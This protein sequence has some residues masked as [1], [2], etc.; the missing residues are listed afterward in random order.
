M[1]NAASVIT[2][3]GEKCPYSLKVKLQN[4]QN[5][6]EVG[7]GFPIDGNGSHATVESLGVGFGNN[8]AAPGSPGM[9]MGDQ[10]LKQFCAHALT[11]VVGVN[12]QMFEFAA[13]GESI[14]G[15]RIQ[16]WYPLFRRKIPAGGQ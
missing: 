9:Q 15:R 5:L 14:P 12:P 6:V 10:V 11:N 7:H 8:F 4:R 16:Q 3:D 13:L 2:A 1:V